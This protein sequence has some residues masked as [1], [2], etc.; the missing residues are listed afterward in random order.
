MRF[1]ITLK[2]SATLR[3]VEEAVAMSPEF[4]LQ[5]NS[6]DQYERS[7]VTGVSGEV[8]VSIDISQA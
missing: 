7:A 2:S 4:Q 5:A 1:P 6:C 3:W 8:A